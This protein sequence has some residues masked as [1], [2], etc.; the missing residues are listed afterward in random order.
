MNIPMSKPLKSFRV[1]MLAGLVSIS[2]VT[3]AQA[4]QFINV[5]DGDSSIA[6][7]SQKD[8]TRIKLQSGKIVD[9]VGDVYDKDRNPNGRITVMADGDSGEIFVQPVHVGGEGYK[10]VTLTL[11]TDMGTY[12]LLLTP[13]D[14]PADA[15][16]MQSKGK[17]QPPGAARPTASYSQEPTRGQTAEFTSSSYV[18]SIKGWMLAMASNRAPEAVDVRR[19]DKKVALWNEVTFTLEDSW[20]GKA[21]VGDRFVLTNVSDRVV[22]LDEREF[23]RDGVLAVTVFKHQVDPGASTPVWILRARAEQD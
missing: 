15:I 11:K 21:M 2:C 18:R 20:I 10:A 6:N 3:P 1:L 8:P 14:M 16:V 12:A 7:V 13:L 23:Y 9:V 22:I 19:I 17:A 4:T 5:R